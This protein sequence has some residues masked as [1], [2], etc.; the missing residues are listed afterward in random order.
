MKEIAKK[1][2]LFFIAKFDFKFNI[3]SLCLSQKLTS[4][5]S[6]LGS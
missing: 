6:D 5:E 1:R 3:F 2:Y 4:F